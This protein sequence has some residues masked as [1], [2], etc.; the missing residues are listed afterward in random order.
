MVHTE[1]AKQQCERTFIGDRQPEE[2]GSFYGIA[3]DV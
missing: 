1:T 3:E 2:T